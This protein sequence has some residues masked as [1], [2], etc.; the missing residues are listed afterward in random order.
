MTTGP[1]W[2]QSGTT[3]ISGRVTDV[4]GQVIPG[5]TVTVTS[6]ATAATRSGV[7]NES[8]LYQFSA[9]PP[10]VYNLTVELTGFRTARLDK[11]ELRV[12]LPAR[13]DVELEVGS[14]TETVNVEA[15]TPLINT[16]DASI[17]N[18]M[19]QEQIRNLP[20]E[21]R[22]VVHLLSLQPGAVFVPINP[23]DPNRRDDPRY[24]SVSGSRAD[25]QNVTLDGIDVNDPQLQIGYTSAV[26]VSQDAL[27]E[28]RVSTSNYGAEQGRSSGAQVS[29]V[30]KS[31][32]NEYTGSRAARRPRAT[33]TS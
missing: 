20:I 4:Q 15:H 13:A 24:G 31:G 5:A 18:T 29:L 30:T 28:F 33:S 21:A 3:S 1:A 17:G 22:N 6:A 16:V 10:G 27:Q 26:R 2:A 7:T 32:S 11:L 25:Q 14:L 8:G 19:S 23:D 12:D 9:L